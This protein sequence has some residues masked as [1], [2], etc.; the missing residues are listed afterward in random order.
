MDSIGQAWMDL[1][2]TLVLDLRAEAGPGD[3]R[4][5]VAPSHPDYHRVL[6]HLGNLRPGAC[7]PV[8]PWPA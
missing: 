1:D 7:C 5:V 8:P 6:A 4:L 2:G 3:G